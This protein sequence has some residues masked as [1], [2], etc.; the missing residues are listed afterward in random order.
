MK[1][2]NFNNAGSSKPFDEVVLSINNFLDLEKNYGGYYAAE[3]FKNK[4]NAFYLNLSKLINCRSN[5]ISFLPSTTFAWNLFFNSIKVTK[6]QNVIIFENEY[7]SNLI[8]L[9]NNDVKFKVVKILKTGEICLDD[10]QKKIDK[11]TKCICICHIAS[12]CGNILDVEKIGK[13][14]KKINK[15]ILYIVDACQSVGHVNVDVKRINCD[16]LVASGRKYLRGPRG[17]GF[18]YINKKLQN[19]LK[20]LILD[21]SNAYIQKKKVKIRSDKTFENFEYSPA[22]K[23]GLNKA[24]EKINYYDINKIELNIK[25]KSLYL[26][27]KL[28]FLSEIYFFENED[29]ISGINTIK[30]KGISSSIIYKYLLNKKILTSISTEIVSDIYFKKNKIKDVLRIS[31]HHYNK[32]NEIDYLIKCLIDLI[33]KKAMI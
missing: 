12:Q 3:K 13:F 11:N 33:K 2:I 22:L 25:N 29:H 8:Y 6:K 32:Y 27:K 30:I 23:L 15:D 9:R 14:I 31:I 24:I 16:V 5:E 26:R 1:Y 17:T 28:K 21:L 10:L 20:P 7:G 18:I 4:I 19:N